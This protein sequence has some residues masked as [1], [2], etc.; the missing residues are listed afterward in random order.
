MVTQIFFRE[1]LPPGAFNIPPEGPLIFVGAPHHNQSMKWKAI[2]FFARLMDSILREREGTN[3]KT[4]FVPKMQIMLSKS[5]NSA[6][7]EVVEVISLHVRKEFGGDSGKGTICIREKIDEGREIG[8]KGLVFKVL[9]LIDQQEMYH[10]VYQ[11]LNE[12]G[13]I[14]IFPE[15]YHISMPIRSRTVVEFG[16]ALNVPAEPVEIFKEGTNKREAI[17]KFLD[18]IYDGLKTGMIRAPDYDTLMLIQAVS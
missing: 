1:I 15:V 14:G 8:E 5:V 12:G 3:F 6:V 16:T 17:A 4:E 2:G 10:G 13:C 18:L 11:K 7:A 9:P